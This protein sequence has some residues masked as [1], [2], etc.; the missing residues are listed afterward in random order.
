MTSTKLTALIVGVTA[1]VAT[2]FSQSISIGGPSSPLKDEISYFNGEVGIEFTLRSKSSVIRSGRDLIVEDLDPTLPKLMGGVVDDRRP[3]SGIADINGTVLHLKL[4]P[5][6]TL[7]ASVPKSAINWIGGNL[8]TVDVFDGP[9][10]S[11]GTPTGERIAS[12][13]TSASL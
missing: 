8:L 4:L 5:D 12:W 9:P 1:L 10:A 7:Q 3:L 2:G 6:R 11:D 13:I